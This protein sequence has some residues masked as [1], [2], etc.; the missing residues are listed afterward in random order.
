[1]FGRSKPSPPQSEP[2]QPPQPPPN[3]PPIDASASASAEACPVDHKARAAWLSQQTLSG[4]AAAPSPP[5]ASTSTSAETCPVDDT[6]RAAWLSQQA[7]AGAAPT[8]SSITSAITPTLNKDREIST[9]PRSTAVADVPNSEHTTAATD[10]GHTSRSGNWIYPSEE[11]FFNAMKRKAHD[12]RAADMRAIVPIHNAV[13]ERA[14]AEIK[15]WEAGR[16]GESCGGP[17]LASF[18]GDAS[19]MS[20]RARINVLLGYQAPFDRHDW[21]VDRCGKKVEYIIDFYAGKKDPRS[22]ER[23]AFYLDV[24]PKLTVEGAAMRVERWAK[25]WWS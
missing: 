17:R 9:I 13:N 16:G 18:A 10:D 25:S 21:V 4:A 12:P 11:M 22:P 19:K 20:P 15:A 1:M 14:W 2:S 8:V 23:L 7:L 24:R 3:H 5:A 6:A